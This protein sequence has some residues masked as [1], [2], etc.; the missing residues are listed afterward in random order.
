LRVDRSRVELTYEREGARMLRALIAYSGSRVI[1]EDAVAEAFARA[2][3]HDGDIRDVSPWVWR[4]A[5][6]L[7]AAEAARQPEPLPATFDASYMQ[8]ETG[9]DLVRALAQLSPK[10]RAAILL[11]HYAG[12]PVRDVAS[13]IE[14]TPPA[15]RVHLSTGRA[16]LRKLLG[17][18]D[19]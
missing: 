3:Q 10:Q 15:V 12:H 8:D 5:F 17:A 11:H 18:S 4:V 19:E 13:I 14:S 16:R 9:A 6:R 2:L 7:A 1:A